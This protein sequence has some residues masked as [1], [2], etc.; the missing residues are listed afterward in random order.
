[1]A[2]KTSSKKILHIVR[3]GTSADQKYIS[4]NFKD[5][6]NVLALNANAVVHTPAAIAKFISE[7][8][9][10]KDYFIDPMTHAFQ[11]KIDHI[12]KKDTKEKKNNSEIKSSISKLVEQFGDP[13]SSKVAAKA[14]IKPADI[15][16]HIKSFCK[17][18]SEFQL[19]Y[20]SRFY[21]TKETEKYIKF[22]EKKGMGLS[23]REPK[24]IIAPYFYLAPNAFSIWLQINID[25][26]YQVKKLYPSKEVVMEIVLDRRILEHPYRTDLINSL[27]S[28]TVK[29]DF[30]LLWI[31]DHKEHEMPEDYL[32]SYINF[33]NELGQVSP[34]IN[35]FGS[36]FSVIVARTNIAPKLVGVGHGPE[37][38]ESRGV[39]PVG[40]G[41][42]VSKFYLPSL[43]R[44]LNFRDAVSAIQSLG[45]FKSKDKFFNV[46]C[47]CLQ[48]STTIKVSPEKDFEHYG[49]TNKKEV[50]T[51]TGSVTKA[52][53]TSGSKDLCVRHY[54]H[55]KKREYTSADYLDVQAICK[56]LDNMGSKLDDALGDLTSHCGTWKNVFKKFV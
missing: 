56:E 55:T 24:F 14:S 5:H 32:E 52:Y 4:G 29:P 35:L 10:G 26:F 18:V 9:P 41:I 15:T 6:Y 25:C 43:H 2:V 21:K 7:K 36:F 30:I 16:S 48:C 50:K 3:Y 44:R 11:H 20:L 33:V 23:L 46:I 13:V 28:L 34:V 1:M 27:K 40:G 8:I 39:V 54:M 17:N 19:N 53:P 22:L 47:D 51:K 42:P 45:C 12:Q 37:Y 38:G 31:D 49:K